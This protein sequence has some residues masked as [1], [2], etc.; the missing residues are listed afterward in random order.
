MK[1]RKSCWTCAARR[2]KCDGALPTCQNCARAQRE[3]QGYGLRLSWP[4][5]GDQ[6]RAI[7][8]TSPPAVMRS[9]RGAR[10]FFIN[11][12]WRDMKIYR[13][14]SLKEQSLYPGQSSP[15]L[16]GQDQ[17]IVN[18]M[19]LVRYFQTSAYLS[20]VTFDVSPSQIRDA[21]MRM[22]LGHDTTAGRALFYAL[23]AFSS[24][25]R[26]GLQQQAMKLKILALQSL[27]A[28]AKEGPL[29]P[30]G[31]AR[32]V[33]AS[34]LLSAFE[35]LLAAD[36]SGEWLCYIQGA[37]H[38]VQTTHLGDQPDEKEIFHLLGWVYYHNTL[39]QFSMHHWH[40]KQSTLNATFIRRPDP[41]ILG[42]ASLMTYRPAL[43]SPHPGHAILNLLSETCDTLIDP[44]DPRSRDEQYHNH[45]RELERRIDRVVVRPTQDKYKEA[46][47]AAMATELYQI[48]T[49]IYLL[50]ASQGPREPSPKLEALI[51]QAYAVPIQRHTCHHFFP[52]FILACEA[53]T[54]E[55]R[56]TVLE[57]IDRTDR[58]KRVGSIRV[59]RTGIQSIWVQ[60]DLHADEDLLVN[61]L[62]L[63][64]AVISSS[65][66]L[67]SFA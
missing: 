4:R 10:L 44:W 48:A 15:E 32:H 60:Q 36:S 53:R 64:R 56:A 31:A 55:R 51:S 59:I 1:P 39:A 6:K 8:R 41:H 12:T 27:F 52:L 24:A 2:V 28:S 62:G 47:E 38:L 23:L 18:H 19:D 33:A 49:Q 57:L 35:T 66:S 9:R 42:H 25:R 20:L 63:L 61:Y 37:M 54:D 3:C 13:D 58:D 14:L 34:M 43:A 21:L 16:W 46:P 17:L 65:T 30:A 11:T 26:S 67:P 50:R 22:V 29:S 40:P 7:T 5:D 45:L